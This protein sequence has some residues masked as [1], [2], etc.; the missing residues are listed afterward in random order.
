MFAYL[1]PVLAAIS[2]GGVG[3]AARSNPVTQLRAELHTP[4]EIAPAVLPY[5]ACLYSA[6]GLPLLRGRDGVQVEFEASGDD[7][8]AERRLAIVNALKLLKGKPVP[9]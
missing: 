2:G 9:A 1:L 8:S 7:C 5:L 4:D 6:R 3:S